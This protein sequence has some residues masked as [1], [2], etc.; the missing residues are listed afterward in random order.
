MNFN[1]SL[2]VT[3]SVILTA[4]INVSAFAGTI[5]PQDSQR[6]ESNRITETTQPQQYC[7]PPFRC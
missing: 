5:T 3:F 6:Q 1:K 2:F 4:G 7:F